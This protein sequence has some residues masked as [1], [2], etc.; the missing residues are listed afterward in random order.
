ML[1]NNEIFYILIALVLFLLYTNWRIEKLSRVENMADELNSLDGLNIEALHHLA[2]MY[3]DGVLKTKSLDVQ[4]NIKCSTL[5]VDSAAK[6]NDGITID[7]SRHD[8][9]QNIKMIQSKKEPA[10][11]SWYDKNGNRKA[12]DMGNRRFGTLLL[13]EKEL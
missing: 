9:G 2:S 7:K 11:I 13:N 8:F 12:Y 10:Y 5:N 4:G 3:K 1:S 6:F